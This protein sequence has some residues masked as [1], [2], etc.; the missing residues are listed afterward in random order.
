MR[1]FWALLVTIGLSGAAIASPYDGLYRPD[2]DWAQ[3]WDCTS[4]GADGGAI[5]FG[6]D[7]YFGIENQCSLSNPT[8]IRGMDATLFD[9]DCSAEGES[10][11]YRLMVM[12]TD[13]G[14]AVIQNRGRVMFLRRCE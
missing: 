1:M 13:A 9:A 14:I 3:G 10:Y 12:A 4:V 11:T 8:P 6:G 7:Q 2:T 5:S